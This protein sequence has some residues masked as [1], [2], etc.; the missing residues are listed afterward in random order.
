MLRVGRRAGRLARRRR[1]RLSFIRRGS[2]IE[3]QGS[4]QCLKQTILSV[5][6][7]EWEM[8]QLR[9]RAE[10]S[11]VSVSAYMRSCVLEAEHL[12]AQGE[13]GPGGDASFPGAATPGTA[14]ASGRQVK[15]R[16]ATG[17]GAKRRG[18]R[19]PDAIEVP[20]VPVRA[21]AGVRCWRRAKAGYIGAFSLAG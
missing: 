5:R 4:E 17:R 19:E 13:A 2:G 20:I 21:V 1:A 6:L 9:E 16:R 18:R 10:E 7:S 15:R 8:E 12:R 3:R 11:G 14:A